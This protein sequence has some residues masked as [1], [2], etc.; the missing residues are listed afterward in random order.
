VLGPGKGSRFGVIVSAWD[1]G[2]TMKRLRVHRIQGPG[3]R[4]QGFRLI[5]RDQA[6]DLWGDLLLWA[7][8]ARPRVW[9]RGIRVWCGMRSLTLN[10]MEP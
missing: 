1:C 6:R 3:S 7:E 2:G 4:D 10:G 9:G 5:D 8:G